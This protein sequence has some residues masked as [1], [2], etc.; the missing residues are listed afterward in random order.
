MLD[1][2]LALYGCDWSEVPERVAGWGLQ[3]AEATQWV[4]QL[5]G[6]R[7]WRERVT[8]AKLAAHFALQDCVEP[9]VSTFERVPENYTCRA[10]HRMLGC[11]PDQLAESQRQRMRAWCLEARMSQSYQRHLLSI[12]E[13]P[14]G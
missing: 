14:P 6:E 1:L 3:P 10:F 13:A 5:T 4:Q 2:V 7:G 12:L 8:A 9:L 11:F